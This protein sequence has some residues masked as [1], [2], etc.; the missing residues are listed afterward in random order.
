VIVTHAM[1]VSGMARSLTGRHTF[2]VDASVTRFD[3]VEVEVNGFYF[4]NYYF[5]Y[6]FNWQF[7]RKQMDYIWT[8]SVVKSSIAFFFPFSFNSLFF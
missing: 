7:V 5:I 1:V 8:Q 3:E 2:A 4:F 6:L